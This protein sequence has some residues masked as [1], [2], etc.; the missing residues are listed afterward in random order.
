MKPAKRKAALRRSEARP[1][2]PSLAKKSRYVR[3]ADGR[4][5][6]PDVFEYETKAGKR[7]PVRPL[8]GTPYV[9]VIHDAAAYQ[10]LLQTRWLFGPE[11]MGP[12]GAMVD[13]R[14]TT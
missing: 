11:H 9:V 2:Q 7:L 14:R 8:D 13:N 10:Q 5:G 1:P 12:A 4:I 6:R 3:S